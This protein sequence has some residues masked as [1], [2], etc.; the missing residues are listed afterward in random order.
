M[1]FIT[2]LV[3]H[4][5]R[6]R[7]T[8]WPLSRQFHL[9]EHNLWGNVNKGVRGRVL[10]SYFLQISGRVKL[11]AGCRGFHQRPLAAHLSSSQSRSNDDRT[12]WWGEMGFLMHA[13]F[14]AAT[15][16]NSPLRADDSLRHIVRL[17]AAAHQSSANHL[18]LWILELERCIFK[19]RMCVYQQL[20]H[21]CV[22][23]FFT[24]VTLHEHDVQPQMTWR[25]P[26]MVI[27]M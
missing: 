25:R 22:V 2:S 23:L 21:C 18:Q 14:S 7:V 17:R 19:S 8:H 11:D 1:T 24:S 4:T 9:M 5:G 15:R 26:F 6:L 16:V 20:N 10:T 12:P 13:Q 3:D 27:F